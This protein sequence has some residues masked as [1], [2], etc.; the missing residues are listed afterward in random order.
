MS[1]NDKVEV[2]IVGAGPA[3]LTCAYSLAKR[4]AEVVV[5]ERGEYPGAKNMF[6]GI[7]FSS[8]MEK[9]FPEFFDEAPW[10]RFVGKRKFSILAGKSELA[11]DMMPSAFNEKPYNHSFITLR[12]T[13]DGWLAKKA[14]G[15]GVSIITDYCVS[16][17]LYEKGKIV[18][19]TS[20][21]GDEDN[22]LADMIVC[23]EG[24]NS[25]LTEKAKLRK[26]IDPER[27]SIAIK[28]NMRLP[29]NVI[30]DRFGLAGRQGAA[31]E[32]FGEAV[33][34]LLGNG[35]IYTNKDSLSVGVG[36][37][38]SDF[39]KNRNG[40]NPNDILEDFKSHPSIAPLLKGAEIVEYMA[41]MIPSDGFDSLPKL[42]RDGLLVIGDAAGLLNTS[43]FHEGVNLA[44]ASGIYAADTI[45]EARRKNDFSSQTLSLYEE[46]LKD[47]F[48]LQDIK[49]CKNFLSFLHK[50]KSLINDYPTLMNDI[51][52]DYF[53][54][55]EKPK[56]AV[57]KEIFR[58]VKKNVKFTRLAREMW[59]AWSNLI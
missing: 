16:D 46:K 42:Y 4:G 31:F 1:Q 9:I 28:E 35:F 47:S 55:S 13:M 2:I 50:N 22:L 58:K 52:V 15:A 12:G 8:I 41:H 32:Y 53:R 36:F 27:R 14:E 33:Q 23:A 24:A 45:M 51:L 5:I 19:I 3:G 17:F 57:K 29:Q 43:F 7:F 6:G 37:S 49:N 38:L 21:S 44:M 10:E 48:V 40:K 56:T 20:G 39:I 11:F 18:G 34:G 25:I 26:K 54:V 59:G 30:E